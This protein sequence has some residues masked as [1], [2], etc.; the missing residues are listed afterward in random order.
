MAPRPSVLHARRDRARGDERSRQ[1]DA[2]HLVPL[3]K[4]HVEGP[5]A[6]KDS[7]VVDEAV[8]LA[9]VPLEIGNR[10]LDRVG[11]ADVDGK[12]ARCRA[13]LAT[14]LRG[15]LDA[16]V[17]HVPDREMHAVGGEPQRHGATDALR[18]ARDNH[19]LR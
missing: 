4:V 5:G 10:G 2:Q 19:S 8:G 9:P 18:G 7:G 15:L 3:R 6:W 11:V 16:V 17:L 12:G 13:L 1:V 14:K